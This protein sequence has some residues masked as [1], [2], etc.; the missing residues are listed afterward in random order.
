[1]FRIT[2]EKLKKLSEIEEWGSSEIEEVMKN[3]IEDP[4][5][6]WGGKDEKEAF[7]YLKESGYKWASGVELEKYDPGLTWGYPVVIFLENGK[8]I[9]YVPVEFGRDTDIEPSLD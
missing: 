1:M 7:N 2:K 5:Y 6:I 3:C 9:S 4:I 8:Q